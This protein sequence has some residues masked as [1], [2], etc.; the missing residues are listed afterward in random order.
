MTLQIQI[1]SNRNRVRMRG[2]CQDD[3]AERVMIG[4]AA[5]PKEGRQVRA[6]TWERRAA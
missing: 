2:F 5:G 6:A 1:D 3:Q 4:L